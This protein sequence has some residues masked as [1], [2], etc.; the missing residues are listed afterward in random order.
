[1]RTSAGLRRFPALRGALSRRTYHQDRDT[2]TELNP[3]KPIAVAGGVLYSVPGQALLTFKLLTI[4]DLYLYPCLF[5]NR[6]RPVFRMR[7]YIPA[8]CTR[9]LQITAISRYRWQACK[10]RSTCFCWQGIAYSGSRLRAS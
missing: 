10:Q 9:V 8:P 2:C 7:L 3:G 6:I 1:M 4:I 5:L